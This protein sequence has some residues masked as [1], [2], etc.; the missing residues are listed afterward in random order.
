MHLESTRQNTEVVEAAREARTAQLLDVQPPPLGAVFERDAFERDD[1]MRQT[2]ELQV[3]FRSG[4]V[5]EDEHR[6]RPPGEELFDLKT[7][8][9]QMHNVAADPAYAEVKAALRERLL[10]EPKRTADP[11]LIDDG[12]YFETPPLAGPLPDDAPKPNRQRKNSAP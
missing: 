12:K 8:P 2:L 7:D 3:A 4:P 10:A 1:A 6:A 5:I 9:H 11:R